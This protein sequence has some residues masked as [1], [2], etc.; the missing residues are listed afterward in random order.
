MLKIK[1]LLFLTFSVLLLSCSGDKKTD[2]T[3]DSTNGNASAK[4]A[5]AENYDPNVG[6]GKY[7]NIDVSNFD[8]KMADEGKTVFETN[9][10]SCHNLTAEKLVGPGLKG[11]T[12]IH[13]A[14]WIMNF[15]SNTDAMLKV[16]PELKKQLEMYGVRMPYQNL[17]D[18]Q[19]RAVYEYLRQNDG[20]K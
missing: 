13:T 15:V 17:D 9:C 20:A 3:A 18:S 4:T 2:G 10:A 5:V 14:S 11:I 6:L 8:A 12:K 19:T 1:S 16:D 7:K